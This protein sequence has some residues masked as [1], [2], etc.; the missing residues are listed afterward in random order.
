MIQDLYV[1]LIL[2]ISV[3]LSPQDLVNVSNAS[4]S[5][6]SKFDE[7]F[8]KRLFYSST[9]YQK[10]ALLD[11]NG[12]YRLAV[13]LSLKFERQ[14]NWEPFAT[15]L[16]KLKAAFDAAGIP[17]AE[18]PPLPRF[19]V[20]GSACGK[21]S[22]LE[23]IIGR[24]FLPQ[25][26][27]RFCTLATERCPIEVHLHYCG[28][29][30]EYWELGS[31]EET[32]IRFSRLNTHALRDAISAIQVFNFPK[33]Q[34]PTIHVHL[35]ARNVPDLTLVELSGDSHVA[36]ETV[37]HRAYRV[38]MSYLSDPNTMIIAVS[39]GTRGLAGSTGLG[40]AL[41]YKS[42]TIGVLTMLDKMDPST[43]CLNIL[44]GK[45]FRIPLGQEVVASYW[46]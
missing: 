21:S 16:R 28:T 9:G 2:A 35:Y 15:Q 33:Y 10:P 43:N 14:G 22:V 17:D 20:V 1:D 8:W 38:N 45:E 18:F 24:E 11:Y 5:M 26:N 6:R 32:R 40:L 36:A 39:P 7:A 42:R 13:A 23:R 44:R 25:H 41:A 3:W 29:S 27:S 46:Y 34:Y 30:E 19:A 4:H 31:G 37:Q 12:D